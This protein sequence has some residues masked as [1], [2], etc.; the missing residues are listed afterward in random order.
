[1]KRAGWLFGILPGVAPDAAA[2]DGS[3]HGHEAVEGARLE[4]RSPSR[5]IKEKT[6]RANNAKAA[7]RS[8]FCRLHLGS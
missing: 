4:S 2:D 3:K 6:K 8:P 1:M 5:L 7:G